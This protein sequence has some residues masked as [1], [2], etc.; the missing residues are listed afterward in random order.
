MKIRELIRKLEAVAEKHGDIFVA[1]PLTESRGYYTDVT[2]V[3][4]NKNEGDSFDGYPIVELND[5]KIIVMA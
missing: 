1:V 2:S 3:Q 5:Q 4:V